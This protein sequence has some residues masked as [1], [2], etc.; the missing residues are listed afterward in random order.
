MK[1]VADLVAN[2]L[3]TLTHRVT[4]QTPAGRVDTGFG[5]QHIRLSKADLAHLLQG[6]HLATELQG[7]EYTIT[8][9]LK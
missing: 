8:I 9:G 6:G 2:R 4:D 1:T 5:H 3:P 7:G